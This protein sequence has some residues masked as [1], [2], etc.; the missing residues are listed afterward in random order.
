[1]TSQR[2]PSASLR[3]VI[4]E[5]PYAGDVDRNV[6]YAR[7]AVRDAV[8]RGDAPI[9]SHLLFTQPGILRDDD[10]TERALGIEA[11]LVWGV[12]AAATVVYIDHGIS[13]GM[14]F[15]IERAFREGRPVEY[16]KIGAEQ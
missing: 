5:S 11:G 13:R 14:A 15:G 2:A 4:L 1:M 12:E 7:R 9:A 10:P 8:L 6:K 3:R 16:R